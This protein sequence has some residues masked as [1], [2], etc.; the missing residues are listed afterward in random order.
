MRSRRRNHHRHR[1]GRRGSRN[2]SVA[3]VVVLPRP[4]PPLTTARHG[5]KRKYKQGGIH[6]EFFLAGTLGQEFPVSIMENCVRDLSFAGTLGQEFPV[7]ILENC[8]RDLSFAGTL[9]QEFP[10]SILENC[11][12]RQAFLLFGF[13]WE[14][15]EQRRINGYLSL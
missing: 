10:V 7:S 3:A 4:T 12:G 6:P 8:V 2:H 9:G 1:D 13:G 11:A 15:N 5:R 14:V